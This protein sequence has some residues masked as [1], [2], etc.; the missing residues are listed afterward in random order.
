MKSQRQSLGLLAAGK[1]SWDLVC[2]S[3][4]LVG[5]TILSV[6]AFRDHVLSL[7]VGQARLPTLRTNF[8][9]AHTGN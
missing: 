9:D 2:A 5:Q 7:I 8:S 1:P 3:E 6:H 4:K